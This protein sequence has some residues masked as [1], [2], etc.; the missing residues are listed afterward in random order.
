MRAALWPECPP[1]EHETEMGDYTSGKC[2]AT[3][4]AGDERLAGLLEPSLVDN[5]ES[6]LFH[7]EVDY[8]IVERLVHFRRSISRRT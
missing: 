3:F 2:L 1:E 6:E 4:V 7:R 8:S 5:S